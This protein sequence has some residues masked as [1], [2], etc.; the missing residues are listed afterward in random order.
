MLECNLWQCY[1]YLLILIDLTSFFQLPKKLSWETGVEALKDALRYE[2]SVTRSIK[3]VIATCEADPVETGEK[4]NNEAVVENVNDYHVCPFFLLISSSSSLFITFSYGKQKLN[5]ISLSFAACRLFDRRLLGR[6]IPW[7]TRPRRKDLD[8][9][10]IDE[11]PR[12]IG[13][14][15]VRQKTLG[16][17]IHKQFQT[18][19]KFSIFFATPVHG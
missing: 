19:T 18:Q 13:R 1:Q 5:A 2:A 12:T 16:L 15:F 8:I 9:G 7:S 10:Q 11:E 6:T 4:R 17:N 3:K 14:I